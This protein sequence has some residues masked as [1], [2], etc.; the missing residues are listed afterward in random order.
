MVKAVCILTL[1][2]SPV[3][4]YSLPAKAQTTDTE[5]A[6]IQ[7]TNTQ[8]TAIQTDGI[9]GLYNRSGYLVV[10]ETGNLVDVVEYCSHLRDQAEPRASAF[11]QTFEST[12]TS[13]AIA[14]ANTLNPD[15]VVE[16]GAS[17]CPF[18]EQGGSLRELRQI[19]GDGELPSDFEVAV[20]IAA[21]YTYCPTYRSELGR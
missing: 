7:T 10:D 16:Y 5:S 1:L 18:L 11:W 19:Q 14:V 9:C 21:I 15:A 2:L 20:T 13:D 17:I 8:A 3:F 6:N 12:A 4:A